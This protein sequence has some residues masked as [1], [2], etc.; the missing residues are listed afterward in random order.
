[1]ITKKIL[2]MQLLGSFSFYKGFKMF[3]PGVNHEA[4]NKR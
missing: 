2:V 4:L 3:Y 1:M